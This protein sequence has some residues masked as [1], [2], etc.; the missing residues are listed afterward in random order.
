MTVLAGEPAAVLERIAQY[1]AA[2]AT[3]LMCAFADFPET[4][5]LERFASEVIPVAGG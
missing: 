4:G 2:G 1:R 5:M 3:N